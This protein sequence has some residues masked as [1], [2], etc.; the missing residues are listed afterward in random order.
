[1]KRKRKGGRKEREG[2][3]TGEGNRERKRGSGWESWGEERQRSGMTG[4]ADGKLRDG[5]QRGEWDTATGG[6]FGE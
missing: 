4:R 6:R 2:G 1:M 3:E 5:R